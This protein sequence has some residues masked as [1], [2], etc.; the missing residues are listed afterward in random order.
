[1]LFKIKITQTQRQTKRADQSYYPC[2]N[3]KIEQESD[4]SHTLSLR[5]NTNKQQSTTYVF[6]VSEYDTIHELHL[7]ILYNDTNNFL[8]LRRKFYIYH[9]FS[10]HNMTLDY[11]QNPEMQYHI[12]Q[13]SIIYLLAIYCN[14]YYLLYNHKPISK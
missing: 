4:Q 8:I 6:F 1:M 14:I 11:I 12:Q 13:R 2:T 9:P 7:V 3:K 10:Y 5:K